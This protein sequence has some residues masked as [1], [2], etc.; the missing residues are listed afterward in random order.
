MNLI[1]QREKLEFDQQ[2][3][4]LVSLEGVKDAW[5][6]A[7]V[8]FRDSIMNAA[9]EMGKTVANTYGLNAREV[10]AITAGEIEKALNE[11]SDRFRK[12][13]LEY[14]RRA[15]SKRED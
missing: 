15:A 1:R 5:Y 10:V 12:R 8:E 13:C 4:N 6:S 11:L 3:G 9:N 14:E 7:L 2:A